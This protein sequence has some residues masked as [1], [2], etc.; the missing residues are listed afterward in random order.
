M[1]R[2][3]ALARHIAAAFDDA[4]VAQD[5]VHPEALHVSVIER[6][7][8]RGDDL[9]RHGVAERATPGAMVQ[10][11]ILEVAQE[12]RAGCHRDVLP[13]NDLR[14]AAGTTQLL[15]AAQLGQVRLMIEENFAVQLTPEQQAFG[16]AAA[17]QAT[18]VGHV[19]PR[20]A[21]VGARKVAGHHRQ[22]FDLFWISDCDPRRN[23]ALH[24]SDIAMRGVLPR[25]VVRPHVVTGPTERGL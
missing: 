10:R 17:A 4:L 11:R 21:A 7:A 12:T 14:V 15:A 3:A 6:Q 24:A 25:L 16:V 5:A 1:A 2:V 9:V 22:C 13:L 20:F 18:A 8:S 19:A 23:V